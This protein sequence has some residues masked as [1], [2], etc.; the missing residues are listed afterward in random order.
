MNSLSCVSF[1]LHLALFADF[2]YFNWPAVQEGVVRSRR[3]YRMHCRGHQALHSKSKIILTVGSRQSRVD[4]RHPAGADLNLILEYSSIPGVR[5]FF[6]S[7][8]FGAILLAHYIWRST[9]IRMNPR[10]T[11]SPQRRPVCPNRQW[12]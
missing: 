1:S 10:V 12:H 3:V 8:Y 7:T 9:W 6:Q 2:E 5:R 4:W 11:L